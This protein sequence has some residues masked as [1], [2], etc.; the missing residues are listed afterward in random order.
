MLRV[1]LLPNQFSALANNR[2]KPLPQKLFEGAFVV[3]PD[4][5]QD[6]KSRNELHMSAVIADKIVT[7]T[8]IKQTLDALL[9]TRGIEITVKET[10]HPSFLKG[11]VGVVIYEGTPIG[12]IGE[13]N[14]KVL[15]NFGLITPVAAFEINIEKL[16]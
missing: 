12:V 9:R 15:E 7:Y 4:E 2:N 3:I 13:T 11:R 10:S 16:L 8:Q 1:S 5:T 6:V 14:P